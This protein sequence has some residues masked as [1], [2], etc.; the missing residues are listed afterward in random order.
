MREFEVWNEDS[1]DEVST[2]KALDAEHAA[3]EW[4]EADDSNSA[5]YAIVSQRSE[6]VLS[7]KDGEGKIR[8]FK[9]SGEAVPSYT[10]REQP[11]PRDKEG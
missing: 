9:V 4:A 8:R 1:P 10:A 7:V 3:E 2:I 11:A 6:P 5:E